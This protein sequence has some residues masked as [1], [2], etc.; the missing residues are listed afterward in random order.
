MRPRMATPE[1]CLRTL[2][3]ALSIRVE[4]ARELMPTIPRGDVGEVQLMLE[5]IVRD[6]LGPAG[7][8]R[9]KRIQDENLRRNLGPE[10]VRI[11]ESGDR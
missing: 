6:R 4:D 2:A 10:F 1:G 3:D 5:A 7:L 8:W 11:L 9:L